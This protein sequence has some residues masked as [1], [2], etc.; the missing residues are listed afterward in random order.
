MC[1]CSDGITNGG[2]KYPPLPPFGKFTNL[3]VSNSLTTTNV[4]AT[5]YHGDGGLLS[6][7]TSGF[8][9]PLANLVVSNSVTTTN[10]FTTGNVGIGSATPGAMLDVVT[11][12]TP[13][14]GSVIVQFGTSETA[15]LQ[16]YDENGGIPPY[17]YGAA[18]NG[19]GLASSGP[20]I[21][22]PN[23]NFGTPIMIMNNGEI[24][25]SAQF[26]AHTPSQRT[27]AVFNISNG[28]G[29]GF[30]HYLF[31]S[32]ASAG[33]SYTLAVADTDNVYGPSFAP[34]SMVNFSR[35]ENNR[36]NNF[37]LEFAQISNN[38]PDHSDYGVG[39]GFYDSGL[40]SASTGRSPF[41]ICPHNT[42][43]FG[44]AATQQAAISIAM[45]GSKNVGIG[46]TSPSSSLTVYG[47]VFMT[48]STEAIPPTPMTANPTTISGQSYGNGSYTAS[49]SVSDTNGGNGWFLFDGDTNAT[50]FSQEN[51]YDSGGYVG[52]V[53]TTVGGTPV[54]GETVQIQFPSAFSIS[55]YTLW[56]GVPSGDL[57]G[58]WVVAGSNDG[59]TWTQVD[60]QARSWTDWSSGHITVSGLSGAAYSYYIL[61]VTVTVPGSGSNFQLAEWSLVIYSTGDPELTVIGSALVSNSLTTTN[62]FATVYHGDGG[63]LSNITTG[64]VQPLANL[65]VSNSVTTTNATIT[66]TLGVDGAMT[67]NTDNT[68]F[69]Y[70]TFTIPYINTQILNVASMIGI[71]NVTSLNV[72]SLFAN[73]LIVYGANTLNVLG[74]SNLNALTTTN[75]ITTGSAIVST[76]EP[77][78]DVFT[79][80]ATSNL[81]YASQVND[82]GLNFSGLT[83]A[84]G[85]TPNSPIALNIITRDNYDT[86]PSGSA[87][88]PAPLFHME[89]VSN[90]LGAGA[91]GM[92]FGFQDK[93]GGCPNFIITPHGA[94]NFDDTEG[95]YHGMPPSLTMWT[96]GTQSIQTGGNLGVN[97]IPACALE[98][99]L[100]ATPGVGEL[101]SEFRVGGTGTAFQIIDRTNTTVPAYISSDY[102]F[103]IRSSGYLDFWVNST[104]GTSSMRIT[105]AGQVGIGT[106]TPGA[107][108]Q[109]TGNIYA[110]NAL[111][112]DKVFATTA[113]VRTLNVATISN[114]NSLTTNVTSTVANVRTLNVATISNLNSLTTNVTSTVANIGTLNVFQISN[115][116]SLTTNV[117][118]TIANIGTLN[119]FQISNLNS[120]TTNVTSTV[121]N[122]GTLNVFQISNLNSLTTNV[123]A[124]T[125]NVGTLNVWQIS[126]LSTLTVT[127]NLY[128]SNAVS[129]TNVFAA[130]EILTGTTGQTTLNVTGNLYVSNAITTTN[131]TCAGFTSNVSNTIF[132]YDTL[133]IP[134]ISCTTLN[135]ASTANVLTLSIPGSTG[136]TT[137]NATGNVYVSNAVTTTNV[138]A[139]TVSTTNPIP[140]R[141]RI[142]NG[143]MNIWQR[144][145]ASTST[146]ASVYTTAD[147][148][149]GALGTTNLTLAQFAGPTEAPQ[150]A[151]ALQIAT[152]TIASGTPLVEQRIENVNISDFLNGTPVS[153]SFWAGQKVGTLMPLTVGLYYATAVSNF[154]TQTLAV[155]A[156]QN[157]PTLTTGNVYYSLSFTLSTSLG[158]TNGLS[159]RFTTGGATSAGSTFL[160][161]GVQV[162]KGALVTPFELRPYGTELLLAQR[163]YYQ[164][165]SPTAAVQGSGAVYAIFGTATGITTT[166]FWMPV[167]FPVTMRTPN[168]T[169]S[170]SAVTN[171]QLLPT[172][173]TTITS[174]GL[175]TDS[176]TPI[177][178]TLNFVG[179]NI[180]A[181]GSYI[182]RTNNLT[183]STTAFFGFSCE[184]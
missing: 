16:F 115:L 29:G 114:L 148:W 157:T 176:F 105:T 82:N 41:I 126:N 96:D 88:G 4:F 166:A 177:S 52:S 44:N 89:L 12:A 70:D 35:I 179:T 180:T 120:L 178:A 32:D 133:V 124:A 103:A 26:Y 111:T 94:G 149:C 168:Y 112:A 38:A 78:Y 87:I 165:T 49:G 122:I 143:A 63:L 71:T 60:S 147:R 75:I 102:D 144:T 146:A 24:E 68:T 174:V 84:P 42:L 54:G 136:Q 85:I 66:G 65:V 92:G 98:V 113:N 1:D 25:A 138:F 101:I 36:E 7:I 140:F 22:Y 15:R 40:Q 150:F 153:V 173:T 139:N 151:N 129:T 9:Q 33:H 76:P 161:T 31:A 91:T 170:N 28:D 181:G 10:I 99:N 156:T 123:F 110:S 116:N 46:T 69:F 34:N 182:F 159:L 125:A 64:L 118:S 39:F 184:L 37:H 183:G 13:G 2:P 21:F 162:E 73:T 3:Y 56:Q 47:N 121:A 152:T 167:Q 83:L 100:N 104:I 172:G 6:N 67:S 169:F 72:Q 62:V 155:A 19:L 48:A 59:A 132:N 171:F 50:L 18:G 14:T 30:H 135:V 131:L 17:I 53:S 79:K 45:D 175:Q 55:S 127:N 145:V 134:F 57:P 58:S 158:S 61:I 163:Y 93:V 20:I 97:Y 141:N 154:G 74:I 119:V 117:T 77:P 137:L 106:T 80:T 109:V 11:T 164:L 108:L 90:C 142:I 130:T 95:T 8:V 160:L 51:Q 128:A 5:V 81:I 23:G 86:V 27:G 107:T 43:P